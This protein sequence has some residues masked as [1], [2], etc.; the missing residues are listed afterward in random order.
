[1]SKSA[2]L[3][4]ALYSMVAITPPMEWRRWGPETEKQ[5]FGPF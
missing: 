5:A 4:E 1:M 2:D 3:A